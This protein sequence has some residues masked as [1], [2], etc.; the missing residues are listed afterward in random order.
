MLD[1]GLWLEGV[2][3]GDGNLSEITETAKKAPPMWLCHGNSD[4]VTDYEAT[5]QF[6]E[7]VNLKDKTFKT[8]E[9][10]YHRL[11]SEPEG[12]KEQFV[13]DITAWILERS[14]PPTGTAQGGNSNIKAPAGA[15]EGDQAPGRVAIEEEET[16]SKL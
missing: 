7:V 4:Q 8:Y 11:H 5:R 3:N 16:K 14:S 6:I 1:R 2:A 10:G 15:T 9:G 13:K 12:I